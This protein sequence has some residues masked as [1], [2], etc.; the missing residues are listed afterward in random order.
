MK[1]THIRYKTEILSS[2]CC[3]CPSNLN[4][5][6]NSKKENLISHKISTVN[7]LSVIKSC[8]IDV[9][10]IKDKAFNKNIKIFLLELKNNLNQMQKEK[11]KKLN[12]LE[13]EISKKKS[14]LIKKI[15]SSSKT[16]QNKKC[17]KNN[18]IRNKDNINFSDIKFE[19]LLLKSLN[20]IAE[21]YIEKIDN[22]IFKKE[23]EYNYLKIWNCVSEK[24]TLCDK[25]KFDPLISKILHKKKLELRNNLTLIA[26]A[27]QHQNNDIEATNQDLIKLK[28]FIKRKKEGFIDNKEVIQEESKDFSQSI[29]LNKLAINNTNNL[30]NAYN[31]KQNEEMY[32]DNIIIIDYFDDE[33]FNRNPSSISLKKEKNKKDI[34]INNI[35]QLISV[36]MNINF[37]VYINRLFGNDNINNNHRNNNDIINKL[38][39]NKKKKKLS[40]TRSLPNINHIKKDIFDSSINSYTKNIFKG[41]SNNKKC[42]FNNSKEIKNIHL[43]TN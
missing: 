17:N 39:K 29:T 9:L 33:Y 41:N 28:N 4:D 18:V 10:S 38:N 25:Q 31:N 34:N 19:I 11:N 43:I 35:Q 3:S 24:E 26:S 21:N 32:N 16:V 42:K 27:N 15:H 14:Y 20:F 37:N 30:I 12:C 2:K 8:E 36:N 6:K 22:I 13:N 23:N 1:K 7:L 40:S 5:K